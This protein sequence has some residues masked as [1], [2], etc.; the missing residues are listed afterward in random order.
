MDSGNQEYS[1]AS[2]FSHLHLQAQGELNL[3]GIG[4]STTFFRDALSKY[5]VKAHVFKHGDFKNAPN[6]LTEQSY[7]REHM[8][9]VSNI[10]NETNRHLCDGIS[11]MRGISNDPKVWALIQN[12]GTFT[13]L[14]AQKLG[15]IDYMPVL[16]PLD[17]LV[18]SNKNDSSKEEMKSKWGKNTDMHHFL[19]KE[20]MELRDYMTLLE[21]RKKRRDRSWKIHSALT[22]LTEKSTATRAVLS[23]L[24]YEAPYYNID[25]V[26]ALCMCLSTE[27]TSIVDSL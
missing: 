15:L 9:N 20:K 2:V 4:S 21:K 13:A 26:R 23:A 3:F 10:V 17:Q 7:T 22:Q 5:G 24:G 25:K 16:D 8:E 27:V 14:D 11:F 12:H 19:A 1:L 6:S 18:A